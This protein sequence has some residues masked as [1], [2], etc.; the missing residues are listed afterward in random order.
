MV[1]IILSDGAATIREPKESIKKHI[2]RH[3]RAAWILKYRD[4]SGCTTKAAIK[5]FNEMEAAK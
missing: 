2:A 5:A 3:T 4:L 1:S